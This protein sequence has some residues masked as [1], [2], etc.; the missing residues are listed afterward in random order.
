MKRFTR[1]PGRG[2]SS[3]LRPARIS[4]STVRRLSHYYRVLEEVEAEGKRLIS[5]HRLAEREGVTSA[6]VRKDLSCFGSFGRRGLG[7]NVAHLR[8]EIR[9]ILGLDRRWRVAIVGAGNIGA[10]L[11]AYR[12]FARQGFD[13]VAVFDRDPQRV[14]Q[15]MGDLVVRHTEDLSQVA[16]E[17]RVD[18]GVIATP[19]RAAQEVADQLVAVGVRAILNFAPRKL[20]SAA[21]HGLRP[22][23][24]SDEARLLPQVSSSHR[25]SRG[26]ALLS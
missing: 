24:V 23:R 15:R 22:L 8:D 4:E 14:G 2:E 13:V 12:G 16:A 17:A 6:Q 9:G 18:M 10:A 3:R 25:S 11:L 26:R 21:R 1:R 20:S 7:Y 19:V 5:S